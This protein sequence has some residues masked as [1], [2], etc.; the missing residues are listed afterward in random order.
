MCNIV[1]RQMTFQNFANTVVKVK[2][3]QIETDFIAQLDQGLLLMV[4]KPTSNLKIIEID[5]LTF[6]YSCHTKNQQ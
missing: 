6:L 4:R 3:E 5:N 1:Y 2:N